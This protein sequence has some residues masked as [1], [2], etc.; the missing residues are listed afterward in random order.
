VRKSLFTHTRC[1]VDYNIN[2]QRI[3]LSFFFCNFSFFFPSFPLF[4][5]FFV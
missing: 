2:P 5:F 1:I 3:P 4:S